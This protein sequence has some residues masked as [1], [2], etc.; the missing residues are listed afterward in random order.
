MTWAP[1]VTIFSS[2]QFRALP[3]TVCRALACAC[4]I[5]NLKYTCGNIIWCYNQTWRPGGAHDTHRFTLHWPDWLLLPCARVRAVLALVAGLA[6]L[7]PLASVGLSGPVVGSGGVVHAGQL[8]AVEHA[9][10]VGVEDLPC[11]GLGLG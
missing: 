7:A 3:A 1:P 5:Y 6:S 11:L 8:V 2:V 9:V 4:G 10:A